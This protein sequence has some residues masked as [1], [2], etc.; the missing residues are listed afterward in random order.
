MPIYSLDGIRP[1]LPVSGECYVAPDA[2][3][4]GRVRVSE[5]ASIWF[6]AVLR[7]DNEWIHIGA[8][9]NV[10][11]GCVLH[12]DPGFPLEVGAGCTI[13]HRAVLHGCT[14]G[15]NSLVGMGAVILNGARIGKN[16]V[17][18]AGSLVTEGKSFGDNSLVVGAPARAIRTLDAEGVEMLRSAARVYR[19]RLKRY[20]AGLRPVQ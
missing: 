8:G 9:S 13:G 1:E 14:I 2:A 15:E 6:T 3:L 19:E 11:D 18:G 7:G 10:Q 5:G 12:T 20:A 16:C 4:I 17:V